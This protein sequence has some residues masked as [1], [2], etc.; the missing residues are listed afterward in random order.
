[1]S[2]APARR[3]SPVAPSPAAREAIDRRAAWLAPLVRSVLWPLVRVE[4]VGA[5]HL[6]RTGPCLVLANHV[7]QLDPVLVALAAGRAIQWMASESLL[8]DGA[9]G[10]LAVPMGIVPKKKFTTDA[11]AVL[12]LVRWTRAGACV[13]VFPEGQRPWDGRP[14]P[15]LPGIERLARAVG[16]PVVTCRIEN[17]DHHW[18]RWAAV[19][20]AGRVRVTF[21]PPETWG[22]DADLEAVRATLERRLRVGD[23]GFRAPVWGVA[24]ARGLGNVLFACPACGAVEGLSEAG[25]TVTCRAC[26]AGWTVDA[27]LGLHP[28]GGGASTSVRSASDALRARLLA[29]GMADPALAA[30]GLVLESEPLTLVDRTGDTPAPIGRGRLRLTPERLELDGDAAWSVPLAALV[31]V[32]AEQRRRLWLRTA[33][34]LYEPVLPRESVCK[35]EWVAEWWRRRAAG[36]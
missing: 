2:A 9:L 3:L 26:G 18:P 1:M 33:D 14:A 25:D 20:R 22:A 6:P 36:A 31:S 28:R 24:L 11:R 7:S 16:C 29:A 17:A 35:W 4:A 12:D 15:L 23:D 10:R 5:A 30:R 32:S 8:E 19:P 34:R 21:D 27:A 13:G